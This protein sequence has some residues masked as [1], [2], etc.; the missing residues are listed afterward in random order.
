LK[1][2]GEPLWYRLGLIPEPPWWV[3]ALIGYALLGS[4]GFLIGSGGNPSEPNASSVSTGIEFASALAAGWTF[5]VWTKL[6]PQ[7]WRRPG[8]GPL[9]RASEHAA[10]LQASVHE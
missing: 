6:R 4:I 10:A 1:G 5:F 8:R 7:V 3:Q 2:K 9:A